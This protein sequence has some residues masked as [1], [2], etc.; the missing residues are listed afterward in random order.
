MRPMTRASTGFVLALSVLLAACSGGD[1]SAGSAGSPGSSAGAPWNVIT[2]VQLH[3][4]MAEGDV[5][6]VNVH[7]PFEGDI[8][9]TDASIPYTDIAERLNELPFGTQPVVIYCRSGNMSTQAA[10]AMVAAGAPP[11]SELGGGFYAWQDAG[12]PLETT[13]F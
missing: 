1:G 3:D 7:V 10:Q 6:L 12:Y 9:G 11:F 13:Q 2:P 5:Y 8:P 4:M